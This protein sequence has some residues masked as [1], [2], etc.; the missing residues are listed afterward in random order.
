MAEF[1]WIARYFAPLARSEGAAGLRDDVAELDTEGGSII[2]TVDALVEDVHFL[3]TDPIDTIARKLVRVN[4]SDMIAKGARPRE[5]LLTLGW[6]KG[7]PEGDLA[8]FARALGE[9][10]DV[11]GA[12]LIGGD[13]VSSPHGLFLSMTLTGVCDD[14]GP[15]RRAGAQTG[16]ALWLSGDIGA[17]GLGLQAARG[18]TTDEEML[19]RYRVPQIPHLG[20]SDIVAK[21]AT[22]SIDVSDGLFADALQ[23]AE[24]S[25]VAVDIDLGAVPLVRSQDSVEGII[26]LCTSG[27][28][29]QTLFIAKPENHDDILEMARSIGIELS[30][31]GNIRTGSGLRLS[32]ENEIVNHPETMGF[33]HD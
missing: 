12:R 32:Y 20:L 9:E 4:V 1:D 6:P 11:W 21:H 30:L 23:L 25:G 10:L 18:E 7:R 14:K 24:T 19:V 31:I 26:S 28:D 2:V 8:A 5:A 22:A 3:A 17:G 27:D 16:E 29:Y 33:Q 15:V 13:T